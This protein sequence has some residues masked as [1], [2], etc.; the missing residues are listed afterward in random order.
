MKKGAM[1]SLRIHGP[2]IFRRNTVPDSNQVQPGLP[3]DRPTH[4][5]TTPFQQFTSNGQYSKERAYQLMACRG[6][7]EARHQA[8]HRSTLARALRRTDH[9]TC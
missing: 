2:I 4:P 7:E 8:E 1:E 3:Q 5:L 9:E 6:D